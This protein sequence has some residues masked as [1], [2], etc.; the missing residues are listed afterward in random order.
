MHLPDVESQKEI[1][2][3]SAFYL[4]L[5]TSNQPKE[6]LVFFFKKCLAIFSFLIPINLF[7]DLTF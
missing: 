7:I 1:S 5:H 2:S 4:I 3:K 6:F